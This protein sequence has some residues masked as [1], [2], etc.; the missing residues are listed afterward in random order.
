MA[1]FPGYKGQLLDVDLTA[2]T[3][4]AVP[5]DNG[6]GRFGKPVQPGVD[7]LDL[8]DLPEKLRLLCGRGRP[9]GG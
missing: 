8:P 7:I 3:S 4:Q 5:L 2:G 6:N 9:G 1:G